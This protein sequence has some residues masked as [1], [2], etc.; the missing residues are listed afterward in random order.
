MK[1]FSSIFS[2]KVSKTLSFDYWL[3]KNSYYHTQVISFYGSFASQHARVLHVQSGNGYMLHALKPSV[4]VGV[5]LDESFRYEAQETYAGYQ[6]YGSVQEIPDQLFD[7][8]L[9]SCS[10]MEADDIHTLLTSLARVSGPHTRI[11]MER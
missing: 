2:Q 8:I 11:V 1:Q 9:L 6:F 10:T 7:L 3:S 5:E 4:G